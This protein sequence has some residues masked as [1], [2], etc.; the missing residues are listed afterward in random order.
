[1]T[2]QAQTSMKLILADAYK[3]ARQA[4]EGQLDDDG[5]DHFDHCEAVAEIIELVM[6]HD[7][8]LLAA[9]YLHD[10][11]EDTDTSEQQLRHLFNDD[12]ADLVIEVTKVDGEF[13]NLKTERGVILKYADRL[14]NLSRMQVW[15]AA[16]RANY[17]N[18]SNFWRK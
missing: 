2:Q 4:H 10:T 5:S 9:A 16:K 1:M 7:V 3:Y 6:P 18:K 11:L 8:N 17:V 15:P 14:H 13:I 12:V